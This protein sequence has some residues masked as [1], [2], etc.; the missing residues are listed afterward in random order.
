MVE[1]DPFA[2]FKRLKNGERPGGRPGTGAAWSNMPSEP[3]MSRLSESFFPTRICPAGK[4]AQFLT[5]ENFRSVLGL[6]SGVRA[7]SG[8]KGGWRDCPCGLL[9]ILQWKC[10]KLAGGDSISPMGDGG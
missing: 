2:K 5:L 1:F 9:H 4:R 10:P 8:G 6:D 3:V 7:A